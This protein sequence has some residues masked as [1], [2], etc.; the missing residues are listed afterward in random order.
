LRFVNRYLSL[1]DLLAHLRACDVFVTPYP[2]KDQIASGTMAYAMAVVGAVISTPYLYAREMLADGR[3]LLV[4]F[5]DS[6]CLA[7]AAI[8]L[9]TDERGCHSQQFRI[10]HGQF[11]LEGAQWCAGDVEGE[12]ALDLN[13]ARTRQDPWMSRLASAAAR[14]RV[15]GT[16]HG[17][18]WRKR[19]CG[20]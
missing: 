12:L 3:G 19:S 17:S 15:R 8:L 14:S 1:P 2:G 5:S 11:D 18:R 20:G 16:L 4:P 7:Q 6:D 9:L 13:R 10:R